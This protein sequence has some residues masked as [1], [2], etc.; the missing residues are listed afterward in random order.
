MARDSERGFTLMEVLVAMTLLGLLMAA[1]SG[2]IGFVGRS[3]DRSWRA[4]EASAAYSRVEGTIRG[5]VERAFPASVRI[6]K[7][8]RFLF[9]GTEQRL[10]LVADGVPGGIGGG[11]HVQEI[12][13]EDT[14]I[15]R[16][17][18]YRRYPFRA[19]GAPPQQVESA[20]L[21]TGDLA[22]AF[23]YYGSPRPPAPPAWVESWPSDRTLPDLIRLTIR[24]RDG[25]VWPQIV[26][27]PIISAE[28]ACVRSTEGGLCR[29]AAAAK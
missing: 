7:G 22:F 4:S 10:K 12:L 2:S 5:M 21:L 20:P 18:V 28:F 11:L 26:V 25:E 6:E 29:H 27:R 13:V 19:N 23:A 3:W 15:G 1:L 24:S 14:A 9:E 16:Q 17:L 8:Q